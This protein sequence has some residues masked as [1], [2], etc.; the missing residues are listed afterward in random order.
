MP[1]PWS[2]NEWL[3]AAL[4]A[5]AVLVTYYPA[6]QC[7]FVNYDDTRYVYENPHLRAGLSPRG[8]YWGLT[9]GYFAIWH[10]LVWWSFLLD[11]ELYGQQA[12]GYH[13]TSLLFHLANTLLLF[14]AL[15]RLTGTTW[16][17]FFVAALFGVHPLN[18]QSVA[19]ISERKGVISAFFW[20]LTLWAYARYAER[21]SWRRYS[22]VA[23]S[24]ALGLMAK[25]TL[26]TLPCVLLLLDYWPLGRW[27]PASRAGPGTGQSGETSRTLSRLIM[28]KLPLFALSIAAGALILAVQSSGKGHASLASYPLEVRVKNAFVSYVTYLGQAVV[29]VNFAVHYPHPGSEIPGW[30]VLA[31]ATLLLAITGVAVRQARRRPY[32]IVGWLWYLGTLAPVSGLVQLGAYSRADRYV[33]IPMVGIFIAVVWGLRDLTQRYA[34]RVVLPLAGPALLAL[35]LVSWAELRH[36]HNSVTLFDHAIAVTGGCDIAHNNLGFALSKTDK[37]RAVEHLRKALEFHES[38][39]PHCNLGQIFSDEGDLVAATQQFVTA[40]RLDPDYPAGHFH[41]GCVLLRQGD[42]EAAAFHFRETLRLDA[43]REDSHSENVAAAHNQLGL[44]YSRLGRL[45]EACRH[46]QE[47][48]L[49]E[50][51]NPGARVNLGTV[52]IQRNNVSAATAEFMEALRLDPRTAQAHVN[53]GLLCLRQGEPDRSAAHF[54]EALDLEPGNVD[55]LLNLG[56]ALLEQGDAA[57]ALGY[58]AAAAAKASSHPGAHFNLGVTYLV[59]GRNRDAV[60][61]LRRVIALQPQ[62]ASARRELAYAL[63]LEGR[64]KEAQSEYQESLRLDPTWPAAI[65]SMV[66][67]LVTHADERRRRVGQALRLAREACEATGGRDPR[68]LDVLA[69]ALAAAGR[70][71]EATA[72]AERAAASAAERGQPELSVA[73]TDRIR[74]YERGRPFVEALP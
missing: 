1:S 72:T 46:F 25:Q 70:F 62:M 60:E 54:R 43:L 55:F 28:E 14:A 56:T 67:P 37:P 74:L 18:V 64:E 17:A 63:Q 24:L 50:P 57:A 66:W 16:P 15:R 22:L 33:Y 6:L 49:R 10:P 27:Q 2:K 26:I 41:L 3:A 68:A 36:W 40:L 35:P 30:Q 71:P 9:T 11:Y 32:L 73:I 59:L 53:L 65:S 13:L 39:T 8:L 5:G 7:E 34:P 19:L 52:F 42:I 61:S 23:L 69:A 12:W 38:A 29:P 44:C 51:N 48:L 45:D 31:A 21:P 47:S 20:M 4:L 58:F